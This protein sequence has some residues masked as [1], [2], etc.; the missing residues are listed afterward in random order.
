MSVKRARAKTLTEFMHQ[1]NVRN[2]ALI[3][4]RI[5]A[6][7]TAVLLTDDEGVVVANQLMVEV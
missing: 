4:A 2:Q 3:D 5:S 6:I 1:H 7:K